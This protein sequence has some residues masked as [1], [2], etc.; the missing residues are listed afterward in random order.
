[1]STG[2]DRRGAAA[3]GTSARANS[4]TVG[5]LTLELTG[6]QLDALAE[7]V[8]A[9]LGERA[10]PAPPTWLGARGAAAHLVCSVGRIHDLVAL[11]K[12]TPRRDGRRLL[13]RRDDLDAYLEGT[14]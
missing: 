14:A 12:L 5:T 6:E 13:F 7:L 1:V 3:T 4:A 10:A 9:R 8:A 11:G 2:A